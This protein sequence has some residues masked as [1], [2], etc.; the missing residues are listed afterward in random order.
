MHEDELEMY[1]S[2]YIDKQLEDQEDIKTETKTGGKKN[3]VC[4]IHK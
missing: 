1:I 3:E 2:Q 4:C